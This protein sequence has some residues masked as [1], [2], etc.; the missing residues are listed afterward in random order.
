MSQAHRSSTANAFKSRLEKRE[1]ML[2]DIVM[3]KVLIKK[4][5]KKKK[6]TLRTL[7]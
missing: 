1:M 2:T 6:I 3:N 5:K 7:F 4:K